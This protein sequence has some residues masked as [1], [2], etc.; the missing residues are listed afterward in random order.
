MELL[1]GRVSLA[2]QTVYRISV[3]FS[4]M[5]P[6]LRFPHLYSAVADSLLTGSS[7]LRLLCPLLTTAYLWHPASTPLQGPQ[8]HSSNQLPY[9]LP[10]SSTVQVGTCSFTHAGTALSLWGSLPSDFGAALHP[11]CYLAVPDFGSLDTLESVI[12]SLPTHDWVFCFFGKNKARNRKKAT[13]R[14][15]NTAC[16]SLSTGKLLSLI[17]SCLQQHLSFIL[18][19]HLYTLSEVAPPTPHPFSRAINA[20]SLHKV[21]FF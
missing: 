14:G 19:Y 8:L 17:P 1:K 3:S 11:F 20:S 2:F 13:V 9:L 4:A 7:N 5:P 21:L 16:I 15:R 6:F 10:G 12:P 18:L